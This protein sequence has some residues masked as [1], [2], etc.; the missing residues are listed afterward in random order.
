MKKISLQDIYPNCKWS[1]RQRNG[2]ENIALTSDFPL[3]IGPFFL[4]LTFTASFSDV[5]ALVLSPCKNCKLLQT[6]TG[7]CSKRQW[8]GK[9]R[10][11]F[12]LVSG[13]TAYYSY[14]LEQVFL[15]SPILGLSIY[16]M[17]FI[18][19]CSIIS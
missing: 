10:A 2:Q 13:I 7:S 5:C 17:R 15:T 1:F 14:N 3:H 19:V 16:K 4:F 6:G 12:L 11:R 9:R 18:V 8:A